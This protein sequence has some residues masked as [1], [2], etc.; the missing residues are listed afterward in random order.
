MRSL[1]AQYVEARVRADYP[2]M[3]A[4]L[5]KVDQIKKPREKFV[6]EVRVRYA[7]PRSHT[8]QQAEVKVFQLQKVELVEMSVEL[9]R[10][11]VRYRAPDRAR[12]AAMAEPTPAEL[13]SSVVPDELLTSVA[14][15]F[16]YDLRTLEAASDEAQQ[17]YAIAR[18][19]RQAE[20]LAYRDKKFL[21]I[22]NELVARDEV[23]TTSR[24]ETIWLRNDEGDR[25]VMLDW[26][27]EERRASEFLHAAT[28]S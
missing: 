26:G 20:W 21:S 11:T 6:G 24:T 3:H 10:M 25:K 4:L 22:L 5:S 7:D 16:G 12:V 9:A 19:R 8:M 2:A 15:D 28:S 13:D 23:P 18:L 17:V 27:A 14:S 1:A